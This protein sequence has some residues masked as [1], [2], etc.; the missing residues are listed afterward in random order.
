VVSGILSPTM[1]LQSCILHQ[2]RTEALVTLA[3]LPYVPL[4]LSVIV[5]RCHRRLQAQMRGSLHAHILASHQENPKSRT[6]D[7]EREAFSLWSVLRASTSGALDFTFPWCESAWFRLR[8]KPANFTNLESIRR[9]SK[10]VTDS[11]QRP[12]A[13]VVPPQPKENYQEDNVSSV[14]PTCSPRVQ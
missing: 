2:D 11:K 12:R 9:E 5:A 4:S 7:V 13:H 6:P 1:R 14:P 10:T 3:A 8:K